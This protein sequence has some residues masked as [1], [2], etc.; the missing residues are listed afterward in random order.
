MCPPPFTKI[1]NECY[2]LSSSPASWLDA[3]FECKDKNAKLAE[4][5]K[6]SDRLLRKYLVERGRTRGNIWI[7][8]MF[9]W[10]KNRWSWGN[11]LYISTPL[12]TLTFFP[13]TNIASGYNGR[14]MAYQSFSQMKP[15]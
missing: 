2:Y 14:D 1:G 7:G 3:H 10:S 15:G 5:Y 4:L 11:Y 6:Y 8:G 9:D 12:L 13:S